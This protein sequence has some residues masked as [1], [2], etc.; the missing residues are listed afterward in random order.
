MKRIFVINKKMFFPILIIL[1][2]F[3]IINFMAIL[4]AEG[5]QHSFYLVRCFFYLSNFLFYLVYLV[6]TTENGSLINILIFSIISIILDAYIIQVIINLIRVI[7]CMFS[8]Q[9]RVWACRCVAFSSC[10]LF[11]GIVPK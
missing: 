11:Y 2:I 6:L 5:I 7:L 3:L 4:G 8:P 10:R 9:V 1:F